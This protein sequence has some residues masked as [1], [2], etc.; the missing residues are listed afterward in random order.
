MVDYYHSLGKAP[1]MRSIARARQQCLGTVG[2]TFLDRY[3]RNR[4]FRRRI[5]HIDR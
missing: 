5:W 1:R 3:T 4:K 2:R